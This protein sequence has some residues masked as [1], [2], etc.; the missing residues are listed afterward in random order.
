MKIVWE[1]F[2][3]EDFEKLCYQI[4]ELNN[5][6]NL[7]WFGKKGSD[8]GRDILAHKF[9]EPLPNIKKE[10]LWLVQCKRFIN[11]K[12]G[13]N[14]IVSLLNSALEHKPNY[15]L[16]ILTNTL[17]ANTKDWLKSIRTNYTFTIVIWEEMDLVREIIKHKKYLVES[18]P[19][20]Y[21]QSSEIIFYNVND[22]TLYFGCNEFDDLEIKV[23]GKSS[24]QEAES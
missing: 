2:T 4:L 23:H 14:E 16:L 17:T 15:V 5:F 20:I 24:L 21:K 13:K 3:P 22:D 6:Q 19:Q 11:K 9:N 12:I 1:N 10:E 7:S 18:F 8:K